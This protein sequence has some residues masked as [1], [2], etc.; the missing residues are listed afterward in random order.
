MTINHLG[1]GYDMPAQRSS[2]QRR[3]AP[4]EPPAK[5]KIVMERLGAGSRQRESFFLPRSGREKKRWGVEERRGRIE[6]TLVK[7]K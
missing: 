7:E 5:C 2:Q 1:R 3:S 6:A 4:A